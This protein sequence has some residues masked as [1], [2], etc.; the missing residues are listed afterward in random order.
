MSDIK[1]FKG[2]ENIRPN[3][4]KKQFYE[5]SSGC[6]HF[7]LFSHRKY[8]T[9]R[10]FY[11]MIISCQKGQIRIRG[12][13]IPDPQHWWYPLSELWIRI[14]ICIHFGRLDPDL[15]GPK[16]PTKWQKWRKFKFWSARCSLLRNEDLSC[17]LDVLYEGLGISKQKFL[18]IKTLDLDPDPYWNQ[19]GS[20]TLT[21]YT[22]SL[23]NSMDPFLPLLRRYNNHKEWAPPE[24]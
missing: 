8:R 19:C 22:S 12:T 10:L 20:T 6:L 9:H 7:G 16:W 15:R 5:I 13:I 11:E 18:V 17:C 23:K 3:Y 1:L 4:K 14:R 24:N 21:L 2:K